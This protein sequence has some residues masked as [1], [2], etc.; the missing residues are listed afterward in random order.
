MLSKPSYLLTLLAFCAGI[1][2]SRA[3]QKFANLGDFKLENGQVIQ[4]CKVG[5]R[6][7]GK[8]NAQ[9]SNA[10]LI[11]TWF[12]GVS[13]NLKGMASPGSMADST[14]FFVI[15][16]DAIG[17]G[18][19]SSPS[20]SPKQLNDKFPLFTIRDMVNSQHE[21]VAKQLKLPHLYAVMGVSMGGMQ[22]Y[23]W[24]VSYPDFMD[25]VVPIVGTPRQSSYDVLFWNLELRTLERG[26][27]SREA[28]K[29]T[30]LIH[31]LNLLTPEY[32]QKKRPLTEAISYIEGVEK[33]QDVINPYNWASQIRAMLTQDV[34]QGKSLEET[35]KAV[36]AKM[37]IIVATQDHMVNPASAME[38]AKFAKAPLVELTG[39]CGHLATS[40]ESEK[41]N[42]FIR[43]FYGL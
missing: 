11:L 31:E 36:K 34:T 7:F 5:Y 22:S 6:T 40:C 3:Q 42:A 13:E 4:D 38:F 9:K 1:L 2:T 10:I 18:V 17:N 35:A 32:S 28:M 33:N 37:M 24:A 8:L 39:N 19:S 23:Q 21:L 27:Y 26:H 12:G 15:T 41:V 30:G 20:N 14:H 25:R 16:V 43:S 29:T